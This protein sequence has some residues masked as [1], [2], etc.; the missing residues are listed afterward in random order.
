MLNRVRL[1]VCFLAAGLMLGGCAGFEPFSE[2]GDKPVG[3]PESDQLTAGEAAFAKK[4]TSAPGLNLEG[5]KS[6]WGEV[7]KALTRGELTVYRWRQTATVTP[8][9]GQ[10]ASPDPVVFSCLAM[11]IVNQSDTVV[12]ATSE[13]RC[14]DYRLMPAW[15]PTITQS[16]DGARGPVKSL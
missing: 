15:Q 14:L 6:Q 10:G 3:D 4:L 9:P 1:A 11:F 13:G 5:L 7:E 12:D 16:S 8:P 2:G